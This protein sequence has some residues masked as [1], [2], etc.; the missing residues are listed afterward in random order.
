ME[1]DTVF[2]FGEYW[3][4]TLPLS[5]FEEAVKK[6][7]AGNY[8]YVVKYEV[9]RQGDVSFW[10]RTLIGW[11]IKRYNLNTV[12]KRYEKNPEI[13]AYLVDAFSR[14]HKTFIEAQTPE[15]FEIFAENYFDKIET[16]S[17]NELEVILKK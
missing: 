10:V 11:F 17:I 5:S 6:A 3:C 1:N 13:R 16:I 9:V 14:G 7:Y 12:I 4:I 8:S 15:G 2:G